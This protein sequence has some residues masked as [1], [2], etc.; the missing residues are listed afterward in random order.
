M[1]GG[2][3]LD[4]MDKE[5]IDSLDEREKNFFTCLITVQKNEC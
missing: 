1:L 3:A 2:G 4:R 5:V